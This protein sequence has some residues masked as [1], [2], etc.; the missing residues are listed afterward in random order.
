MDIGEKSTLVLERMRRPKAFCPVSHMYSPLNLCACS[1]MMDE[2]TMD[3]G[4][5]YIEDWIYYGM[6]GNTYDVQID[7]VASGIMLLRCVEIWWWKT[8][9]QLPQSVILIRLCRRC[10]WASGRER[11]RKRYRAQIKSTMDTLYTFG[12]L[13]SNGA[14]AVEYI[15]QAKYNFTNFLSRY[16]SPVVCRR[17]SVGEKRCISFSQT[18]VVHVGVRLVVCRVLII[19]WSSFS[20]FE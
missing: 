8:I 16:R 13:N 10:H 9:S 18:K 12:V 19:P 1:K 15:R 11:E 4:F 14:G 2:N 3:T 7:R 6:N 5:H 17:Q 20:E